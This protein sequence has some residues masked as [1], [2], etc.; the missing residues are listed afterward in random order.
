MAQQ[1][2][3]FFFAYVAVDLA[4]QAARAAEAEGGA[5]LNRNAREG[6]WNCFFK[7]DRQF[8]AWA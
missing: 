6:Q 3:F 5:L 4:A 1:G 2:P 7:Q 8:L